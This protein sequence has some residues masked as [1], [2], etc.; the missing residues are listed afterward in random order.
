MSSGPSVTLLQ[1]LAAKTNRLV[2]AACKVMGAGERHIE[3]G[4]LRIVRTHSDGLFQLRDRLVRSTVEGECQSKIT[5][6]GGEVRIEI[7]G[8]LEFLYRLVGAPHRVAHI[9]EREMRPWVAVVEF[10]RTGGER[11]R[12]AAELD[13][14][15][16][17]AH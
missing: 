2:V 17:W 11:R 9:A 3:F 8:A 13:N 1:G 4:V 12:R 5:I 10:R 15:D 7:N 14:S 6:S 16:P